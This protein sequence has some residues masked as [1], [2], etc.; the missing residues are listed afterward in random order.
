MFNLVR[1]LNIAVLIKILYHLSPSS[2]FWTS[3][4]RWHAETQRVGN[5][6]LE[7]SCM[8]SCEKWRQVWL[9]LPYWSLPSPNTDYFDWSLPQRLRYLEVTLTTLTGMLTD[10]LRSKGPSQSSP[11][12]QPGREAH[13]QLLWIC[14][15][16]STHIGHIVNGAAVT[17]SL[18]YQLPSMWLCLPTG[19]PGLTCWTAAQ[20]NTAGSSS[21]ALL[22]HRTLQNEKPRKKIPGLHGK[23]EFF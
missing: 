16:S 2:P 23:E 10:Y 13:G 14:I 5:S 21:D 17:L 18:P 3:N 4:L 20:R 19:L 11:Q 1:L 22:T 6:I 9:K 8:D 7:N 12:A 15:P